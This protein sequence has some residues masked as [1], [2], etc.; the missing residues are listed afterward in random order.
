[1]SHFATGHPDLRALLAWVS[2]TEAGVFYPS[3]GEDSFVSY[4]DLYAQALSLAGA[5]Q[6]KGLKPGVAVPLI[7]SEPDQC[8]PAL[9]A[10]I[11]CGAVPVPLS[12]PSR[13]YRRDDIDRIASIWEQLSGPPILTSTGLAAVLQ[14]E[15]PPSQEL[16]IWVPSDLEPAHFQQIPE[17]NPDDLAL[18]QYSSGSTSHPKGVRITHGMVMANVTQIIRRCGLEPTDLECGWVPLY[19]DLGIFGCHF[20][21]LAAGMS[22]IRMTPEEFLQDPLAWLLLIDKHKVTY[23]SGTNGALKHLLRRLGSEPE[24]SPTLANLSL[25]SLRFFGIGAEPIAPAILRLVQRTL[26]A[27][28]MD[29]DVLRPSY[30]LA[31]ACL[32]VSVA[33]PRQGFRTGYYSNFSI[34][35]AVVSH[36]GN[37]PPPAIELVDAGPT[38]DGCEIRIVDHDDSALRDSHCGYIQIRG[39]NVTSGYFGDVAPVK[40]VGDGWWRTGD[41]GFLEDGRIFIT[42]RVRELIK[43]AGRNY[44]PSDIEQIADSMKKVQTAVV[45]SGLNP[46]NSEEQ[47][48]VFVVPARNSGDAIQ[49]LNAVKATINETFGLPVHSAVEIGNRDIPRTSSGK[50]RRFRL[51]QEWAAGRFAQ[52][53]LLGPAD[54]P[55]A[56]HYSEGSLRTKIR[57]I[58]AALLEIPY[59]AVRGD[60]PFMQVG[61]TSVLA[62]ELL[63]RLEALVGRRLQ[64][65]FLLTHTTIEQMVDAL[66]TPSLESTIHGAGAPKTAQESQFAIIGSA[67]RFPGANTVEDYYAL[68]RTGKSAIRALSEERFAR[69][70]IE[71][72]H[73]QFGGFLDDPFAFDPNYF[74][75]PEREALLMDPQQRLLLELSAELLEQCGY[76][77][78]ARKKSRIAVYVGSNHVT[79]QEVLIQP[80]H[81]RQAFDL[82]QQSDA[83]SQLS[84]SSQQ[85]LQN[86]MGSLSQEPFNDP[87][88]LVGNLLN[89]LA[90]RISHE[91]DLTGPALGLDTAC[92]TSLVATSLG[93]EAIANGEA[94]LAIAGGVHLSLTTS[95][96]RYFDNAGALSRTG[97]CRSFS[98]QADGFIPGEGGGLVLI[99]GLNSALRDGDRILGVIQG[100]AINNDGRSVGTMAPNPIGQEAVLKMA[101]KRAG[102]ENDAI[103]M[104]EAH[105][106]ATPLG[107]SC[108]LR[109]LTDFFS[110][111]KETLSL[112]SAK[113]N[114]GH[115][116]GGAGVA[117]L[118][119][120]VE[121]VRRREL[122]PSLHCNG[123]NTRTDPKGPLRVQQTVEPWPVS[124]PA[125][126][127]INAFGF[128][129]TNC[130]VIVSEPPKPQDTPQVSWPVAMALS[131]PTGAYMGP[132][133]KSLREFSKTTNDGGAQFANEMT[134]GRSAMAYR[135]ATVLRG[136]D[137]LDSQL[138]HLMG[139]EKGRWIS[140]STPQQSRAPKLVFMF[141]GQGAQYVR[142]GH[143]LMTRFP[144]LRR[145]LH[146]ILAGLPHMKSLLASGYGAHATAES[147]ANT[148][149]AQPLLIAF[150]IA[151]VDF[152]AELGIRPSAV[153]GHS[154]GEYAA[155]YAAGILSAEDAMTLVA[156]RGELIDDHCTQGS[157]IA[158]KTTAEKASQF[159]A[160]AK[161]ALQLAAT[162]AP[163][164]V[165]FSGDHES[166]EA[167]SNFLR[168]RE[169]QCR[170]LSTSH[171]FHSSMMDPALEAFREVASNVTGKPPHI[172]F[173]STVAG[174]AIREFTPN[175]WVRQI[176]EPVAFA[177]ALGAMDVADRHFVEIGPSD[178]LSSLVLQI[179]PSLPRSK[180]VPLT[181]SENAQAR[182]PERF[183][184]GILELWTAGLSIEFSALQDGGSKQLRAPTIA[185]QRTSYRAV[186]P[187]KFSETST[188]RR[189]PGE[190]LHQTKVSPVSDWEEGS[191]SGTW[192]VLGGERWSFQ[193]SKQVISVKSSDDFSR[194]GRYNYCLNPAHPEHLSWLLEGLR[195]DE[196]DH[197]LWTYEPA[198]AEEA[199]AYGWSLIRLCAEL[200]RRESS[201]SLFVVTPN[202]WSDVAGIGVSPSARYMAV[203]GQTLATEL[204]HT[205]IMVLDPDTSYSHLATSLPDPHGQARIW[206]ND[207][208][209]ELTFRS[210]NPEDIHNNEPFIVSEGT[211]VVF[212]GSGG[213]G[214]ALAHFI[215]ENAPHATIYLTG[216]RAQPLVQSGLDKLSSLGVTARYQVLDS[217]DEN[218]VL[219]FL[220]KVIQTHGNISGVV[221][222]P[223]FAQG[224][225]LL[226]RTHETYQNIVA[227][228]TLG[229]D[230]L[231]RCVAQIQS[232]NHVVLLSSVSASVS[233]FAKGLG[234]YGAANAYLD[235]TCEKLRGAR[236]R[237]VSLAYALW[238]DAGWGTDFSVR[239]AAE[240]VGITPLTLQQA[241]HGFEKATQSPHPHV[242]IVAPQ[243]LTSVPSP[244]K[245]PANIKKKT[246][247]A[248]GP[249]EPVLE[250]P[251]QVTSAT[252]R[253]SQHS[254]SSIETL[255]R[256]LVA[257]SVG[258]EPADIEADSH[259][260]SLG[261]TS[262]AGVDI[263]KELEA[264][265]DCDLPDSLLFEY[266]NLSKLTQRLIEVAG[267]PP[268]EEPM[269][270]MSPPANHPTNTQSGSFELLDAQKT[271][272]ANQRFYPDVPC[273]IILSTELSGVLQ[274]QFLQYA[275]DYVVE[276]HAML[277]T[278]FKF[279]D[280]G[281]R[282]REQMS[283][284]A[285]VEVVN[286]K[287]G[288]QADTF[289]DDFRNRI[290]NLEEG[291]LLALACVHLA[292]GRTRLMLNVHHIVADAWSAQVVFL[293]ILDCYTQLIA[294]EKAL[295]PPLET[296]FRSCATAMFEQAKGDTGDKSSEYWRRVLEN[297]PSPLRLPNTHPEREPSGGCHH[298]QVEFDSQDTELLRDWAKEQAVSVFQLILA[299][300]VW[301]LHEWSGSSD[302]IV[303]IA[304]A[305]RELRIPGI[306]GAV[307]CFADSLPLR[308]PVKSG[309]SLSSLAKDI[310]HRVKQCQDHPITSSLELADIHQG[311]SRSG[312]RGITP[313]GFSFPDF[314]APTSFGGHRASNFRAGS[315]SGFSQLGLI[316]WIWDG[317]LHLSWNAQSSYIAKHDLETLAQKFKFYLENIVQGDSQ[318]TLP[319]TQELEPSQEPSVEPGLLDERIFRAA[320]NYPE[321]VA[322]RYLDESIDYRTLHRDAS[323]IARALGNKGALAGSYIGILA[324]PGVAATRGVLGILS[325]RA[326]YVPMDPTY[327]D[328]RIGKIVESANLNIVVTTAA[329]LPRARVILPEG[330]FLVAEPEHRHGKGLI[331]WDP[332]EEPSHAP[333][334][335]SLDSPAYVMFTSGTTGQPKGVVVSHRAVGHFHDWVHQAFAVSSHDKFIQ[336]SALSFGGSIRQIYSP[337][338]AGATVFPVPPEVKRDPFALIGF[339]E[340][341]RISIWNSVP[342]LWTRISEALQTLG[343][344]GTPPKLDALRWVLIGGEKVTPD[345]ARKWIEVFGFKAR[346]ANLYG[347]TETVVNA[348]WYEITSMP[349]S[350]AL[351]IPI[352]KARTKSELHLL[353]ENGDPVTGE[354]VGMLY[355]GG[356]SIADGYLHNPEATAQAFVLRGNPGERVYRTGDLVRALPSGD[357]V[358]VGREDSQVKIRGN[359]VEL[360][361]IEATLGQH[362][363]I[364][365]VGVFEHQDDHRQWLVAVCESQDK[366]LAEDELRVFLRRELP[367]F[368]IPHRFEMV[369][370]MPLTQAGKLDRL[371][372]REL[373]FT[374]RT[375][376]VPDPKIKDI[377]NKMI[378][379]W[380]ALLGRT[381][382]G[383]DDDFFALG[384]D[385]ILALDLIRRVGDAFGSAPR[386]VV[387]Y[388]ATTVSLL[389]QELE[390]HLSAQKHATPTQPKPIEAGAFYLTPVQE[391]FILAQRLRPHRS[392]NWCAAIPIIGHLEPAILQ[393]ALN[394][395]VARRPM[396]R[397]SFLSQN[398]TTMQQVHAT[399]DWTI[400][401]HELNESPSAN[402]PSRADILHAERNHLFNLET[403]PLLRLSLLKSTNGHSELLICVH[404]AICDAWSLH[405]I[406]SDLLT[407]YAVIRQGQQAQLAPIGGSYRQVVEHLAEPVAQAEQHL[408]YWRDTYA[409]PWEG[410]V[411]P[412]PEGTAPV[413]RSLTQT[414]SKHATLSLRTLAA[415]HAVSLFVL[416][417]TA[418][419][420]AIRTMVHAQEV[421]VGLADSGRAI[422]V[423]DIENIVGCFAAGLPLRIELPEGSLSEELAAVG[424]AIG[425]AFEHARIGASAMSAAV[426]RHAGSP[427]PPGG[428][429]FMS[430]MDFKNF[431]QL[432]TDDVTLN[433]D[434]ADLSFDIESAGGELSCNV[435]VLDQLRLNVHAFVPTTVA[436]TLLQNLVGELEAMAAFQLPNVAPA[437][438]P[439]STI[440]SA[441][442]CYLPDPASL[443]ATIAPQVAHALRDS[444]FPLRAPRLMEI[445]HTPFGRSGAVFLPY[446]ANE[447][448]SVP[449]LSLRSTLV[450]ASRLAQEAGAS[451][452]SFAGLLPSLTGYGLELVGEL[453]AACP[454][455]QRTT[456]HGATVCAVVANTRSVLERLQIPIQRTRLGILGFG[457]IGQACLN[458]TLRVLGPPRTVVVFD[459]SCNR[460]AIEK[461]LAGLREDWGLTVTFQGVD[462]VIQ[463]GVEH[464][465]LLL[466][467]TSS[468]SVLDA[469]V[470]TP[471]TIVVDDSFP[472]V[473]DQSQAL[474]RMRE[475]QDVLIVG[476]GMLDIHVSNR[477]F[478]ADELPASIREKG[479]HLFARQGM[480]GCRAEALLLA[481]SQ[482]GLPAIEGLVNP[483]TALRYWALVEKLRISPP[484][485]H[486]G[487]W[488]VEQRVFSRVASIWKGRPS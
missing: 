65:E 126:A 294:G 153:I 115:L 17:V 392:P 358:Y 364:K 403:P 420:R 300:Y 255:T 145:K 415:R 91:F 16:N 485:P 296:T 332:V 30:G 206:R 282:Q 83:F 222:A 407:F 451:V 194:T 295:L 329:Y 262:L 288:G 409:Q 261:L 14:E 179:N 402:Q 75:I 81:R 291:P 207:T 304:N 9:W 214:S 351:H 465:D 11:L 55:S 213:L 177:T 152:L 202:A 7:F 285:T 395:V 268:G 135:V 40:R 97:A 180:V 114:I 104:L 47:T 314:P 344:E 481:H 284:K 208:P 421:V 239:M 405:L 436:E 143:A 435:L 18:I 232:V 331:S 88:A 243:N 10:C 382:I 290:F 301:C 32:G 423:E 4:R 200:E 397:T 373:V 72:L 59:D 328:S 210:V 356:P 249:R 33:H 191:H 483:E 406:A 84:A 188:P 410:I 127:G 454:N 306:K 385:S 94:E 53:T 439:R 34:G 240:N 460:V 92:S 484:A 144:I 26:S 137:D 158:L 457:S 448:R 413:G 274:P 434:Q 160:E 371:A 98:K 57:E 273:Y 269:V 447:L 352:G 195:A 361:E 183:L 211:Y 248:E 479:L 388:R 391:G 198:S 209:H 297:P 3:R 107:D 326:A 349:A 68:L 237:W 272:F 466:G 422:D 197:V 383:V 265:L 51:F 482:N 120:A 157:M 464:C 333:V 43:H 175:Y 129:G 277:S 488:D 476:A 242:L 313:A 299:G 315:A 103:A 219:S 134:Q 41:L 193:G 85:S 322:V 463:D 119:K 45:C 100:F 56:R 39:P 124:A 132:Y 473:I 185:M 260:L 308:I 12:P 357:L 35:E 203:L 337:L 264:A 298:I 393:R 192:L 363:A 82:L 334:A 311:R 216:R 116:L 196:V 467:A 2:S 205:R 458:L 440:D 270:E 404:H 149:V 201:V 368:M 123:E 257:D 37:S 254:R 105:G 165:V 142:Q 61:G 173:F 24:Q 181:Y 189:L 442:V 102:L 133:A 425:P 6:V 427:F 327:P 67:C 225:S 431:E 475:Q 44:F 108:E 374:S 187:D 341:H 419:L 221:Y 319:A 452:V 477:E 266:D 487:S 184:E 370:K 226:Q 400:P 176:R 29:P 167:F 263:V 220:E 283:V 384:G 267:I 236:T 303:R 362:P 186:E 23:T 450:Q 28:G 146:A 399:A 343:Q 62:F 359:R 19:H 138:A 136:P 346:I 87:D 1:M 432:S 335:A 416:C 230:M 441:L 251:A 234:E 455:L 76:G 99:K 390:R 20:T 366:G 154:V 223:G 408:D 317:R 394:Q 350:N 155:A 323:G 168:S 63:F 271:F 354:D 386:P 459:L 472:S 312:P 345:S 190:F 369:E 125:K 204:L 453:S 50:I 367:D 380:Q 122:L 470:L 347:S 281:L 396:L 377:E 121:C 224:G 398:R 162:N 199:V 128:G 330:A 471:G 360:A 90:A 342:T 250:A 52:H 348:T 280:A 324:D 64:Q 49:V 174:E 172:P 430:F 433:W 321:R 375:T 252:V 325:S 340:E 445:A 89:M 462:T 302:I 5:M 31:E 310:L 130:H 480:A 244:V 48:V 161:C 338:L 246:R 21:A 378:P 276:R 247:S 70:D 469:T 228:K 159:L 309:T 444:L 22:Q 417:L 25:K 15:L 46:L 212:G 258:T 150:Q 93:C 275:L 292:Q 235:G 54:S 42:G 8:L 428:Q 355:V 111:R 316:G 336:T 69:N 379:I 320:R 293:E 456:G 437:E 305:R 245:V 353:N 339:L 387:L 287:N 78:Q 411:W 60:V 259:F 141:P 106:T 286:L 74:S 426:P 140:Q 156:K 389:S 182:D 474:K 101:H 279:D 95:V 424:C 58:W 256:K 241:L 449:K 461:Q 468:G 372:L 446:F 80:F 169:V 131:T 13:F 318:P 73:C 418:Y 217:L 412:N 289:E 118:I 36:S 27:F 307:G 163:E 66:E 218:S 414:L 71:A 376:P 139:Q 171:G 38:L 148:R 96:F 233:H 253:P 381:E 112:G 166:V 401:V 229:I 365:N 79:H 438:P 429:V 147:I 231:A 77:N 278:V 151:M 227:P 215:A 164:R 113:S 486:L 443:Q 110:G 170:I 478:F 238:R 178:Q 109:S 117:A 86:A